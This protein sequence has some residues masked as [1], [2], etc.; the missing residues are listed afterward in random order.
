MKFAL[1]CQKHAGCCL[2][3]PAEYRQLVLGNRQHGK[4]NL[5]NTGQSLMCHQMSWYM[6]K[7]AHWQRL[8]SVSLST[9]WQRAEYNTVQHVPSSGNCVVGCTSPILWWHRVYFLFFLLFRP[10]QWVAYIY[11][12][13]MCWKCKWLRKQFW[14][15]HNNK[16]NK[17]KNRQLLKKQCSFCK[18]HNIAQR[19][20]KDCR[21]QTH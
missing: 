1:C 6:L 19:F 8:T 17:Q 5:E 10:S 2:V 12:L 20:S 11:I 9:T 14:V 4:F 15:K 3:M 18:Q 7:W 16:T 21:R 13:Y